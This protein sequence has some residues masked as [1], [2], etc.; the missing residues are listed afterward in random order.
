MSLQCCS[1]VLRRLTFKSKCT[2]PSHLALGSRL[3]CLESVVIS[4]E[5][6]LHSSVLL[7]LI[8][9]VL[10][11]RVL[12]RSSVLSL[13][14]SRVLSRGKRWSRSVT[15]K[16]ESRFLQGSLRAFWDVRGKVRNALM[17]LYISV[18]SSQHDTSFACCR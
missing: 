4:L 17:S 18:S 3:F 13:F 15:A 1:V 2:F 12:R 11:F 8:S 5:G 16:I 9:P 7:R 14:H 6:S 10:R